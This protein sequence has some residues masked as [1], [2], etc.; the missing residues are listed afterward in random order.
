VTVVEVGVKYLCREVHKAG[1]TH[2][3]MI[4]KICSKLLEEFMPYL[5]GAT[6]KRGPH[7]TSDV[8]C[9][10]EVPGFGTVKAQWYASTGR[11]KHKSVTV[12]FNREGEKI[13]FSLEQSDAPL[14]LDEIEKRVRKCTGPTVALGA[15][16]ARQRDA[17]TFYPF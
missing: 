10:F 5:I 8:E 15:A 6:W 11:Y 2:F 7:L 12:K 3:V 14:E 17:R 4:E 1:T 16:A 13:E 9:E